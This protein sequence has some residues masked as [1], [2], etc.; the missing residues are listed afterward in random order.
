M[1]T[2]PISFVARGKGNRRRLHA[3]KNERFV[4]GKADSYRKKICRVIRDR[5]LFIAWR[6]GGGRGA[7]DFKG[8]H[9]IFWRTKGGISR[10]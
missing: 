6:W 3:G 10:N 5:S 1:Q 4:E 7:E 8:D 9:L 2:S